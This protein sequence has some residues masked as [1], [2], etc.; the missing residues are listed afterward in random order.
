MESAVDYQLSSNERLKLYEAAKEGNWRAAKGIL[1]GSN[2]PNLE[3]AD[4]TNRMET[5]LHVAT[6]A[7]HANFVS[8]LLNYLEGRLMGEGIRDYLESRDINYNT[9]FLYAVASGNMEIVQIMGEVN[10]SLLTEAGLNKQLSPL[11]LAALQGK[12]EMARYLFHKTGGFVDGYDGSKSLLFLFVKAGIYD[13]ALELLKNLQEARKLAFARDEEGETVL[14]VLSRKPLGSKQTKQY[15]LVEYLWNHIFLELSHEELLVNIRGPPHLA[16]NAV[17]AGNFKFLEHLISTC[18]YLIWE[19]DEKGRSIIH[20]AV[21]SRQADVFN[22]IRGIGA[23]KDMIVQY[24]D[25]DKNNLLHMAAKLSSE[26]QQN[27][28]FGAA[29]YMTLELLWFEVVKKIVPPSFIETKNKEGLTPQQV[30]TEEHKELVCMAQSWIEKATEFFILVTTV[31][32]TGVFTAT[33]SIPGGVDDKTGSPSYL[34]DKKKWFMIF[35]TFDAI[36]MIS[37]STSMFIFLSI[38]LSRHAEHDF[39]YMSLPMKLIF[40]LITL[41]ISIISMMI[42][43]SSAFIMYFNT[44]NQSHGSHHNS[45]LKWL[46]IFICVLSFIPIPLFVYLLRPLWRDVAKLT[47]FSWNLCHPRKN[48]LPSIVRRC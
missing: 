14:H 40:G 12:S 3:S 38:L 42:T 37:S 6:Q 35:S 20:I 27:L 33:F 10:H 2:H 4:L 7:N 19:R 23:I 45:G 29:F 32:T 47:K 15:D 48:M 34:V 44:K 5:I 39:H 1:E 41:L 11:H 28:V 25:E 30:F 17:R 9:A 46:T 21:L 16:F 18:P 13:L 24:Y 31:I 36:A 22:F 8:L 26:Y 43:F